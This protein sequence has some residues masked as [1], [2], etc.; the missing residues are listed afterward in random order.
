M[1]YRLYLIPIGIVVGAFGTLVGAGGGFVLVPLLLALYP[2]LEPSHITSI[3]L[4]VV[5]F[6]A[7]S[8]TFA[9]ARQRRIDYPSGIAFAAATIPGAALGAIATRFLTRSSFDPI[10][11]VALIAL[12][13]M[14]FMAPNRHTKQQ[15]VESKGS[16]RRRFT[17]NDGETYVYSF[18]G[19]LGVRL[20]ALVGFVSSLL[21][22][23]GGII[24]VP[25][26][27]RLLNFPPHIATATSQFVLAVM[28]LV[29]TVVHVVG[30]QFHVG[31]RRTILL[32]IGVAVGAQLGAAYAHRVKSVLIM[33]LLAMALAFV[34]VRLLIWR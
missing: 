27:V 18:N 10:F 31:V 9:Y 21:G 11:G 28:A 24:H 3:S 7:C 5:F 34:G 13:V 1:L 17:D 25:A 20:S 2:D 8:G 16:W 32:A 33:R 19:W 12:A 6:N 15:N 4:A 29:G 14:T 26:L 23:G 30:G 22:I